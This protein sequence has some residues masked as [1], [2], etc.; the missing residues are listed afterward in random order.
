MDV[1]I[2]TMKEEEH[3]ALL[4]KFE[5]TT[6]LR[7]IRRDYDVASV[8]TN[9]GAC[10]VAITRCVQQGNGFAQRAAQEML[11][12]IKPRFLLVVGIAGGVPTEDF[13]LGDVVVSSY[14]QDLTLEDTGTGPG[15]QRYDAKGC[16]LHPS[17]TRIV[18]R[19]R[20]IERHARGWDS[21]ESV[22]CERPGLTGKHTTEDATWNSL[23]DAALAVHARRGSPSGTAQ[24]IASSD[25]LIKDPELLKEWRQVLKSVAAVEMESAGVYLLCQREGVPFMVVRGISDIVGWRRDE[26]WTRYACHTAAAYTRMLVNAGVFVPDASSADG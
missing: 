21:A 14:I 6:Y 3:V 19:L 24:T 16:P 17:A 25:R 23:I 4:D 15:D 22:V 10:R 7:G 2:V 18:E 11:S 20:A 1:G 9:R 13:C 5:P 12:D 26:A 8:S